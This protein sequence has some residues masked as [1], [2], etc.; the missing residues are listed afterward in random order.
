MGEFEGNKNNMFC[1]VSAESDWH[2]FCSEAV[3]LVVFLELFMLICI[4]K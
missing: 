2:W 1:P 3:V 4:S